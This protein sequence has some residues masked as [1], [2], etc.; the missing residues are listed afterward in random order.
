M[1]ASVGIYQAFDVG[2]AERPPTGKDAASVA[3]GAATI[4]PAVSAEN[5]PAKTSEQPS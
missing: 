4:R 5:A 1:E 3:P 2:A